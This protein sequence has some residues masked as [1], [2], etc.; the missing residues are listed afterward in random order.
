MGVDALWEER[1]R[2]G[3]E[4]DGNAMRGHWERWQEDE[5]RH[6]ALDNTRGHS[7]IVID[8]MTQFH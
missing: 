2:H 5:Q 6:F 1:L 3:L 8:G 7:D 4:R